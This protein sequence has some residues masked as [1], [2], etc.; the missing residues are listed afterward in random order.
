L[1]LKKI[2]ESVSIIYYKKIREFELNSAKKM[3]FP[4]IAKKSSLKKVSDINYINKKYDILIYNF[5]S[6][7]PTNLPLW[8]P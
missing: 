6:N 1:N 5:L 3:F 7:I 8:S 4:Q 2:S